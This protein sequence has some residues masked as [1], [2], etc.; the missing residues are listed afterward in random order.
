MQSRSKP[1]SVRLQPTKASS[2]QFSTSSRKTKK[3]N[4]A[5]KKPTSEQ[6]KTSKN[7]N[8]KTVIDRKKST[9]LPD[10]VKMHFK[11]NATSFTSS[12]AQLQHL[13]K[14]QS[15]EKSKYRSEGAGSGMGGVGGGGSRGGGAGGRGGAGGGGGRGG[16]GGGGRGSGG[17]YGGSEKRAGTQPCWHHRCL[18]CIWVDSKTSTICGKTLPKADCQTVGVVYAIVSIK[19]KIA[20]VGET[21][22]RGKDR[23]NVHRRDIDQWKSGREPR[24]TIARYA[25]ENKVGSEDFKFI[26]LEVGKVDKKARRQSESGWMKTLQASGYEL[27]NKRGI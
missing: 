15:V 9:K 10:T 16:G 6:E 22:N 5:N 17:E 11:L 2:S 12:L 19:D 20:Y 24:S 21:G 23:A 25:K 18:N 26:I 4:S 14:T 3:D 27:I 13:V 8:W 1:K 7:D